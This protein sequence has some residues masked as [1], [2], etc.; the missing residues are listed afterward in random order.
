M[1]STNPILRESIIDN[2]QT[3]AISE[4]PMTISGT[5]SKLLILGAILFLGAGATYY[6]FSIGHYDYVNILAWAGII[7]S[8]IAC[9]AISFKHTLV[10]YLSPVYAFAQ[11]AALSA[12]SCFFEAQYKGIVM[13]AVAITFMVVLVMALLYKMNLIR[14][15]ERLRSVLVLSSVSIFIFYLVA[16]G[17]SFFGKSLPYFDVN[18]A[19]YYS[20][21]AIIVNAAIAVIAALYLILDFDFIE[22]G[23]ERQLPSLYEWYGAFGLLTTI[24]WIY[25]EILR[26][27]SRKK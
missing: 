13:Q 27:L 3:Y 22:K 8:L 1:K 17:F 23:A 12:I 16:I 19:Y 11:G 18:N 9:I 20:P 7:V 14:A 21:M 24:L 26:L 15:T 10:P 25:I 4:N 2:S 5:M 6:Q